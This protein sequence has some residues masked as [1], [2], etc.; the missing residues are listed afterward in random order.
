MSKV[1]HILFEARKKKGVEIS[2]VEQETNIEKVYIEALE[3]DN[4]EKIP[5]EA[6]VIGFLRNYAEYLGLDPQEIIRQYKNIKIENVEVPEEILL[7]KRKNNALKVVLIAFL[8]LFII[9]S[10]YL[11]LMLF[12][13]YRAMNKASH[14]EDQDTIK[15]LNNRKIQEYEITQD[16]QFEKELFKGDKIKANIEGE[17]YVITILQTYPTLKLDLEEKGERTIEPSET[18]SFDL[19]DDTVADIEV[20][21]NSISEKED[22]GVSLSI[23]SG[24]DIGKNNI[25]EDLPDELFISESATKK[26]EKHKVLFQGTHPYPVFL[27]AE[28]RGYCLFRVEIDKT[29]RIEEFYQKNG[30]LVNLKAQNGFRIWASNGNVMSCT[31]IGGGTNVDLGIGR[32]GE[33]IVKDLKWIKNEETGKFFF[34]EI[35]VD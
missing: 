22:G 2:Q 28:F 25:A 16:V 35:D 20:T 30:R 13:N 6:Y 12:F 5:A 27:N 21:V 32:P 26:R 19:N 4:Y 29:N 8:V 34:V 15:A 14:N 17:D 33:V 3:K 11:S 31:L 7:P 9:G 1:G 18:K 10:V 24:N 23:A